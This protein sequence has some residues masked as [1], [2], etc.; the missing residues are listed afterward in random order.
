MITNHMIKDVEELYGAESQITKDFK[1]MVEAKVDNDYLVEVY[2]ALM[3][4]DYN[5]EE[6]NDEV[7]FN[8]YLGGY[9]YDC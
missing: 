1:A 6:C 9:D 4:Q 5:Y 3:A 2:E 8:P 7:G